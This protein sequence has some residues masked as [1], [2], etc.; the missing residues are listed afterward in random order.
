[1]LLTFL[2]LNEYRRRR[3][4]KKIKMRSMMKNEKIPKKSSK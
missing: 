3:E 4:R 1:V 2:V